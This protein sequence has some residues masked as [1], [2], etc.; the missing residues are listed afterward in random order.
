M[1]RQHPQNW[2]GLEEDTNA[3]T[4]FD[5]PDIHCWHIETSHF[6]LAD[7]FLNATHEVLGCEVAQFSNADITVEK[8]P[9]RALPG[10]HIEFGVSFLAASTPVNVDYMAALYQYCLRHLCVSATLSNNRDPTHKD[11]RPVLFTRNDGLPGVCVSFAPQW[12]S[13]DVDSSF[14]TI[15][16]ITLAG[17]PVPSPPLP[18]VVQVGANHAPSHA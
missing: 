2:Y 5:F 17:Q 11:L 9:S 13:A 12:G 16:S 6:A 1:K 14:I 8:L 18:A 4:R 10:Y 15:S 3:S 7:I